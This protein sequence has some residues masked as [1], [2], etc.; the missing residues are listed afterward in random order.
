MNHSLPVFRSS[1][2]LRRLLALHLLTFLLFTSVA[3]AHPALAQL[4][5]AQP[6]T[7]RAENETIK[8]VLAQLETQVN[9]HFL[10]SP[11][12]LDAGRRVSMRATRQ[13]LGEVLRSLLAPVAVTY[14][15]VESGVILMPVADVP[16]NGQV[17]D[18]TGAGIPGVTVLQKG[19][20][21]GTQT[22]TEGR[23]T[24]TV[25]TDAT[26]TFSFIGYATQE[27]AVGGRT[28][29]NVTLAADTKTLNEVVVVGYGTQKKRD[30]TG[31]VARVEGKEIVDQ[32]VQTP[33]QA[34]Q[35]KVAGVQITNDA[36]PNSQPIVR[37]RGT[38]T[39]LAGASPL[40]V[41]D[42]VQTTDIRNLSNADIASIDVLKDAS[43]AAIYGVRGANGV[44]I[45]TT[46]Q[47][48]LGKPVLAYSGTEGF[49]EVSRRVK[50]ADAGQYTRYLTDTA[51]DVTLPAN[52]GNTDWYDQI[53]RRGTYR[54]HNLAVSG[55]T[56]NVRYYF[57]G[58]YLQD[59]GL[60]VNNKF[61]RLTVRS[62]TAFTVSKFLTINSQASFSHGNT[63]DDVDF[64]SAYA[65]AYRAAPLIPGRGERLVRQHL[66]LRQRGQPDLGSEQP[67]QPLAGKPAPG[68]HRREPDFAG[69]AHVPLGY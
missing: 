54:N 32:P 37:I 34:M 4:S 12:L 7:L 44:I 27:V 28:L 11:Q 39:L 63:Q 48:K 30:L 15:V 17:V 24:L 36:T 40:Y 26:L 57:S 25:P 19:T 52:P 68:Q 41:V 22:D 42:G 31:A 55:A 51:P 43:A 64:G 67:K 62:N 35:G 9:T 29:L 58:N 21:N 49:R 59:D 69:R 61:S 38:G 20:T 6:V 5:L 2:Q 8:Q 18:E 66:G 56:D 1:R 65:D 10:Y 47:G 14:E 3:S 46:K 33:T 16:V 53:L 60:A 23:F 50:M 45:I 13:P